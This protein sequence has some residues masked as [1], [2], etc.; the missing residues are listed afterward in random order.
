MSVH[1][2]NTAYKVQR[3]GTVEHVMEDAPLAKSRINIDDK[4]A[5]HS[6][7]ATAH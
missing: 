5:P 1:S 7:Y 6:C 3:L 4:R 2:F